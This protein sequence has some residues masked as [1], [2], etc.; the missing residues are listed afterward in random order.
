MSAT[1]RTGRTNHS[2]TTSSLYIVTSQLYK[3]DLGLI[4]RKAT[5]SEILEGRFE[6][7]YPKVGQKA[8]S[9][10]ALI[11]RASASCA[12]SREVGLRPAGQVSEGRRRKSHP[13]KQASIHEGLSA[14]DEAQRDTGGT[15]R[16]ALPT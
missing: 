2:L 9:P 12:Q 13:T 8:S 15:S 3:P 11:R 4:R 10:M 1:N 5:D 6:L 16:G 7:T 14:R